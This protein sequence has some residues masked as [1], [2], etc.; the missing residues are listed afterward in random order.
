MNKNLQESIRV[1]PYPK[2]GE[3]DESLHPPLKTPK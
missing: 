2:V 1:N 3:K